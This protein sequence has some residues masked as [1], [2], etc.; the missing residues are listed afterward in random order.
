MGFTSKKYHATF[1]ADN[2]PL[3]YTP[4][5]WF[6][7]IS[8]QHSN[9]GKLTALYP[10]GHEGKA[11]LWLCYCACGVYFVTLGNTIKNGETKSCGCIQN[12]PNEY[13]VHGVVAHVFLKDRRGNRVGTVV[14]DSEDLPVLLSY[15]WHLVPGRKESYTGYAARN[16]KTAPAVVYM[17]SE[18]LKAHGFVLDGMTADHE[19]RNGLDNRKEN[20][21]VATRKQNTR[22]RAFVPSAAG[23]KGVSRDPD[24]KTRSYQAQIGV[25]SKIIYLGMYATPE[26]AALAYNRAAREH[27]GEFACLNRVRLVVN[28]SI[29]LKAAA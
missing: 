11:L 16:S 29:P 1:T 2:L 3:R 18:I 19:D 26:A 28:K 27:H 20:L 7:D 5:V 4:K 22:N 21:R 17:H 23:Y 24:C 13:E 12:G 8:G 15:R 10:V 6:N 25:D 14:I 9:G